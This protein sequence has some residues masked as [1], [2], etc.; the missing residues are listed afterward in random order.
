MNIPTRSAVISAAMLLTPMALAPPGARAQTPEQMEYERQQREYWKQQ[1]QQRQEQ[2]R[3]QQVM[4]DNA[5]QQQEESRQWNAP[6][7]QSATSD[8]PVAAPQTAPRQPVA[9]AGAPAITAA[10][11]WESTCS[12]PFAGG[13][14]IYVARSTIHRSGTLATMWEMYDFKTAQVI[15]G[16]RVQSNKNLYEYDCKGMRRRML[17]VAG[18]AGHMGKGAVVGFGDGAMPWEPVEAGSLFDVCTLKVACGKK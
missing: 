4:D 7:G 10:T 13:T 17:T 16:K 12:S 6:T 5:R 18:F 1:E 14:D 3:L 9:A 8:Y 2:Q 15:D 11:D